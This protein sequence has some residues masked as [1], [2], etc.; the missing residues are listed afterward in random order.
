[1]AVQ[2]RAR[3]APRQANRM[4]QSPPKERGQDRT[5]VLRPSPPTSTGADAKTGLTSSSRLKRK[6]TIIYVP[7]ARSTCNRDQSSR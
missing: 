6:A 5:F 7:R 1:M 2:E 3:D 4:K